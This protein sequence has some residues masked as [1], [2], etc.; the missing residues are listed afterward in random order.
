LPPAMCG[1]PSNSPLPPLR[2]VIEREWPSAADVGR[3][4]TGARAVRRQLR[5][6]RR[7]PCRAAATVFTPGAARRRP[8]PRR[9]AE[10]RSNRAGTAPAMVSAR[11]KPVRTFRFDT[12]PSRLRRCFP[13]SE[14][15]PPRSLATR[16][17]PPGREV[18]SA[19]RR[20]IRSPPGRDDTPPAAPYR[21]LPGCRHLP[22]YV[23]GLPE[24]FVGIF[25]VFPGIVGR[26]GVFGRCRCRRAR[27]PLAR[28]A[29][30][31][32]LSSR[33]LL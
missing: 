33:C 9:E 30:L 14:P 31:V 11:W 20:V 28:F 18:R 7:A 22:G 3:K 10:L 13:P 2:A 19:R 26:A 24:R 1:T 4:L 16:R 29:G 8:P 17:S 6:G 12:G 25:R 21:H 27:A 23:A 5:S 15:S 32:C